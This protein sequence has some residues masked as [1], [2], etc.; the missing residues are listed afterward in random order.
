MQPFETASD[1]QLARSN[2]PANAVS[3]ADGLAAIILEPHTRELT[4]A[5]KAAVIRAERVRVFIDA[6]A[7]APLSR[8]LLGPVKIADYPPKSLLFCIQNADLICVGVVAGRTE[9]SSDEIESLLS[10]F[11]GKDIEDCK[12]VIRLVTDAPFELGDYISL[13]RPTVPFRVASPGYAETEQDSE[14]DVVR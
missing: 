2:L 7:D 1:T 10:Q 4:E 11:D 8:P 12:F 5:E 6:R 13:H 14:K 9:S 3:I